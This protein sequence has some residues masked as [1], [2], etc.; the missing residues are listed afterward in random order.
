MRK[1]ALIVAPHQDDESLGCGGLILHKTAAGAA[2]VIVFLSDGSRSHPWVQR[3]ELAGKREQE[4]LRAACTL[5]VPTGNV[6][7]LRFE[8]TGLMQQREPASQALA[9]IL[10]S[11]Q[12]EQVFV[13]HRSDVFRDHIAA[14]RIAAAAIVQAGRPCELY[15]YP[16]WLWRHWPWVAPRH[17]SLRQRLVFCVRTMQRLLLLIRDCRYSVDIRDVLD[18]KKAAVFEHKSQMDLLGGPIGYPLLNRVDGGT[19]LDV[20]F[21]E[22]EY[23]CRRR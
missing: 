16:V 19:F 10:R 20:F 18:R 2:V 13:P 14:N 8:D 22:Q 5:G 3:A 9:A 7:F 11:C 17:E 1:S 23:F 12:P 15:E 21:R 4:A 6:I